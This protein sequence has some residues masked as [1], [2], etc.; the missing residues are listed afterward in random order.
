MGIDLEPKEKGFTRFDLES[1]Q[2]HRLVSNIWITYLCGLIIPT[3]EKPKQTIRR[4]NLM[5]TNMQSR[6]RARTHLGVSLDFA[7]G[8]T[9]KTQPWILENHGKSN[10]IIIR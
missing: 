7:K 4:H 6:N 9:S 2:P 8:K 3:N 1:K 5:Q 10:S